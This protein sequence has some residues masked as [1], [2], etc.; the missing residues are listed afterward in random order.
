MPAYIPA[1]FPTPEVFNLKVNEPLFGGP[2]YTIGY[3]LPTDK[4]VADTLVFILNNGSAGW[5]AVWT[6]PGITKK[7]ITVG[8]ESG[9]LWMIPGENSSP[10]LKGQ[11]FYLA[12]WKKQEQYCQVKAISSRMTEVEFMQIVHNLVQLKK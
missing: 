2:V 6:G 9:E 10:A 5:G 1:R 12:S 11:T 4:G 3:W 7:S 8:G